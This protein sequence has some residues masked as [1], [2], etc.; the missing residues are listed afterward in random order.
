M[1]NR[2]F[3][4]KLKE[5]DDAVVGIVV[6]V[7]LIGLILTVMVMINTMYVPQ[8]LEN[9]EAS[10][11]KETS[12]QFIQLKYA[13]DIQT[14]VNDSSAM[15]TPITLGVKD[16]PFFNRGRTFDTLE[17]INDAITIDFTPG[18]SYTSDVIKFSSGNTYFVDQSYVYEAGALIISQDDK[19]VLYG[20]PPI[21]VTEYGKNITFYI[22]EIEGLAGK[23]DAS[24]YGTY[25]IFTRARNPT[26]EIIINNVT[27]ITITTGYPEA[28]KTVFEQTIEEPGFNY[29]ILTSDNEVTLT[30]NIVDNN[31]VDNNFK[32]HNKKIDT[33]IAFG[34]AE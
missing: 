16:I 11:M 10:H 12:N 30:F 6:T 26:N 27:Q 31:I 20:S 2:L 34:L 8:W 22:T 33:Q 1:K 4:V 29:D 7:L 19:S 23:T 15:T 18:G 3:K 17:I 13:L 32:I 5:S 24:G 9:S 14:L 28:W 25:P 21:V